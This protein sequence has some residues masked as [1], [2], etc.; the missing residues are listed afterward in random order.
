MNMKL[1][2]SQVP[3]EYDDDSYFGSV[4]DGSVMVHETAPKAMAKGNI[5][6]EVKPI[7]SLPAIE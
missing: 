4:A 1:R 7:D 5:R 3:I 6:N 2:G